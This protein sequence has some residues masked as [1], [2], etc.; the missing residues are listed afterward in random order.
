MNRKTWL[1]MV[2]AATLAAPAA[3]DDVAE[4]VDR[5][6]AARGG[7]ERLEEV[8]DAR[9]S[10]TMSPAPGLEY[11]FV[12]EWQRPDRMRLELIVDG[13]IGVRA[14]DGRVAWS[15]M[16][17]LGQ[18]EPVRLAPDE[19]EGMRAIATDL[20]AG[21]LLGYRE[22]GHRVE[23]VG[24][25]RVEDWDAY[26]LR[27]RLAGG[28]EQELWLDAEHLLVVRQ[29]TRV[30]IDEEEVDVLTTFG[31]YREVEGL[32][33]PFTYS[34]RLA[35]APTGVSEQILSVESY[36]LDVGLDEARFAL[37][38]AEQETPPRSEGPDARAGGM[39]SMAVS[40][41]P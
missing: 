11:P 31:D 26:R 21:P 33:L 10:G 41:S 6:L 39:L 3:A 17:F 28:E 23:L 32:V 35:G 24:R 9:V 12:I 5:H 25:E 29:Q 34:T 16:P 2:A 40:K 13:Q 38:S 7:V 20:L 14:F 4:I 19:L 8:E 22:K 1:L 36:Q 37:P 15:H 18:E 30:T 27:V